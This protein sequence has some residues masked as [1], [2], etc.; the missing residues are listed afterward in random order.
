MLLVKYF[1]LLRLSILLFIMIGIINVVYGE[2]QEISRNEKNNNKTF[3]NQEP[4]GFLWYG[5]IT[6]KSSEPSSL[7]QTKTNPIQVKEEKIRNAK[8]RNAKLKQEFEDAIELMLDDPSLENAIKAQMIQ[9]KIFDRTDSVSKAWVISTLMEAGLFS[10]DMNPNILHRKITKEEK[11]KQDI[12]DLQEIAKDFGL[13]LY[14]MPRC[15]YCEKFLP[16]IEEL[17]E[18]TGLQI[19]VISESG[20]GYGKFKGRKN[21]GFLN[22]L[23]PEKFA[24]VLFLVN[25][26]GRRIYP[27]AR[28]LTD[29]A[30]LKE[31]ILEMV[32][33]DK[34]RGGK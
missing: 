29:I 34:S 11:E 1:K 25:K 9:K 7:E 28:G 3:Y 19:L 5:K 4:G 10:K 26:D 6:E 30:K 21:N 20:A 24:P 13:F 31:N 32:K 17:Q 15:I 33:I 8:L 14:V 18:E 22:K 2:S 16:I 27:V 12:K 23:N